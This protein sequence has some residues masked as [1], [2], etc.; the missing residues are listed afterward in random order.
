MEVD[1]VV[2]LEPPFNELEITSNIGI[3]FNIGDGSD[4]AKSVA[5]LIVVAPIEAT[6]HSSGIADLTFSNTTTKEERANPVVE[7]LLKDFYFLFLRANLKYVKV[8]CRIQSGRESLLYSLRQYEKFHPFKKAFVSF[9]RT[10]TIPKSTR[11]WSANG[12]KG[13]NFIGLCNY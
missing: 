5:L 1:L 7:D 4:E 8:L 11:L 9:P 13:T 3:P 2:A 10:F 6:T 12:I